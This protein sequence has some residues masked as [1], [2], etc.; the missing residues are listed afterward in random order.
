MRVSI[1]LSLLLIVCL[2]CDSQVKHQRDVANAQE[3]SLPRLG[4]YIIDGDSLII[5]PFEVEVSLN[6][7]ANNKLASDNE[8]VIVAAYFTAVPKNQTVDNLTKDGNV[9]IATARIE[10][11]NSRIAKFDKVKFAKP[12]YAKI[13]NGSIDLLINVFSGRKSS[14][15]NLLTCQTVQ[16]G[17]S[18]F[19]GNKYTVKG[20]LI[21][22]E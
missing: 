2:A 21:Y 18:D 1:I 12:L 6:E 15:S 7:K 9:N 19:K 13:R 4:N 11:V 14:E 17:E 22:D 5:P 16:E 8:T 20:K 10:L 3:G